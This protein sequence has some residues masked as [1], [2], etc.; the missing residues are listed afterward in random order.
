M[1]GFEEDERSV[2]KATN[3]LCPVRAMVVT[4]LTPG[5]NI[6]MPVLVLSVAGH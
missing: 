1:D 6:G 3:I 2:G 4:N 5:L